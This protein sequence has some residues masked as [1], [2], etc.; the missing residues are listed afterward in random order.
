M[1]FT[2]T[3]PAPTI[4]GGYKSYRPYVRSDFKQM[5]AYCLIEELFAA[6]ED[7]FELDHFFP[8]SK[9]PLRKED[10]Y[11]LYYACH[12][13]NHIK[14]AKW[15]DSRLVAKGVG[16]VDLC[17][18]DFEDHFRELPN[19]L[20]EGLTESARYTID[21][22]RLN[23]RHLAEIRLLLKGLSKEAGAS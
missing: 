7:N 11:N 15:P 21:A 17:R 10:F 14:H 23:R 1:K 12:P 4:S 8:A 2:R 13:C 18:D 3:R 5:C 19:G 20:W 22:L 9:F 16:F 6:G